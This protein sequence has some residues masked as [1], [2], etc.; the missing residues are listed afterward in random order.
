MSTRVTKHQN[1]KGEPDDSSGAVPQAHYT[2]QAQGALF[3]VQPDPQRTQRHC[4]LHC[5][6][7][8]RAS[9][10]R[11]TNASM[12]ERTWKVREAMRKNVSIITDKKGGKLLLTNKFLTEVTGGVHCTDLWTL[13]F[14]DL[15]S[16]EAGL[17]CPIFDMYRSRE[18]RTA[19]TSTGWA[20]YDRANYRIGCRRFDKRT[21]NKIM[22]V[23]AMPQV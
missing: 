17:L 8:N 14:E 2:H 4:L 23:A 20:M 5:C 13:Y 1:Q 19:K 21:F 16:T 6:G 10:L 15:R 18:P 12:G 7:T 3:E 9:L 11:C 22:N